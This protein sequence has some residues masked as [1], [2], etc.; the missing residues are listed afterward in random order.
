MADEPT[1]E[2]VLSAAWRLAHE[3]G[4]VRFTLSEVASRAG[5]SRQALYLHFDNRAG[6][7]VAMARRIDHSSG[8][9][10]RIAATGDQPPLPALLQ[11]LRLWHEHLAEILPVARALEAAALTAEDGAEALH[12][13]MRAWHETLHIRIDALAGAGLLRPEWTVDRATDW[14]WA[15]TQPVVYE[16]LVGRSGWTPEAMTEQTIRSVVADLTVP[17]RGDA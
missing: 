6:L 5:I 14:V 2:R 15:R 3:R 16:Y 9:V 4:S 10:R 1:R 12:D 17:A 7:L 11:V 8:F 13:R